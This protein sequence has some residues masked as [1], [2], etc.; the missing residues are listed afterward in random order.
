MCG[1]LNCATYSV[2]TIHSFYGYLAAVYTEEEPSMS[3]E[4]DDKAEEEQEEVDKALDN[5]EVS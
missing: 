3:S 1:S 5:M 2:L 4:L